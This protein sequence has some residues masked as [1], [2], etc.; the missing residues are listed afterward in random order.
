M[1]LVS[2]GVFVPLM[3][4]GAGFVALMITMLARGRPLLVLLGSMLFGTAVSL[5]TALQLG[6]VDIPTDLV[7]LLPFAFLIV[8]LFTF[9]GRAGLPPYLA[10]PYERG[11]R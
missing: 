8:A 11:A 1:V 3:V 9:A 6:G 5:V 4:N 10:R 7:Q 2:A